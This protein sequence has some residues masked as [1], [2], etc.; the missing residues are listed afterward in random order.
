[1]PKYHYGNKY[2]PQSEEVRAGILS[3]AWKPK[4]LSEFCMEL[5]VLLR[6]GVSLV[7]VLDLLAQMDEFSRRE[8]RTYREILCLVRQG[9]SFS[10]ALRKQGTAF[11]PLM[12]YAFQ[13]AEEIGRLDELAENMADYYRKEHKLKEKLAGIYAYPKLLAV[14]IVVILVFLVENVLPQ[15]E[16]IFSLME[17]LPLPTRML[18]GGMTMFRVYW[19]AAAAGIVLFMIIWRRICRITAVRIFLD[20]LLIYLPFTG[21]LWKA[22]YTARFARTLSF[23]YRAGIPLAAGMQFAANTVGNAYISRQLDRAVMRVRAG[24]G[25]GDALGSVVG[26]TPKLAAVV[27]IGGESRSLDVMLGNMASALEYD[28]QAAV[29]RQ[30][31]YL[32]PLMI[33]VMAVIVGFI[34]IAV[35]MPIYESYSAIEM[36]V[37]R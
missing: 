1:M 7:Q 3:R 16:P 6:A 23:L 24:E 22:V 37:S 25:L 34:M 15:F 18:Y 30:I 4:A 2:L 13:A 36:L 27:K 11:P 32:E 17:E 14:L 33:I 5:A 12:I 21:K 9:V 35:M 31:A 10:E 29:T 20:K 26:F 19:P 8:Q 28:A